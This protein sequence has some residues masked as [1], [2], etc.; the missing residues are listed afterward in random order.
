MCGIAG[1]LEFGA[2]ARVDP[3]V[4]RRMCDVMAHRGPD[5]DGFFIQGKIGLGMR[6]LSIVDLSTGHQP[7]GNEDG[8]LWIVF[9]GEIYNHRALRER[10]ITRG[11]QFRTQSDTESIV[12]L[13]E[14]YG[15]NCV[16]HLRGMFA[17]AIWDVKQ[18][19]LFVARDRLGIKPLYYRL[20]PKSFI[21]GSE[22]KVLLAY[23]GATPELNRGALPEFLSF[24]YLSGDESFY[25]GVRKLMPGHRLEID[26][27]G[28]PHVEQYW[29]LALT[30]EEKTHDEEFYVKSYRELLEGAVES[31]LMSDVP[32]GVFL[33]GGLD[34]SAV[35][36]L[37][38]RIRREPVE[39][40]SVGYSEQTYSELPYART[41]AQHLNSVHHEV[42]VSREDFFGALPNLIWHEDEPIVWPSSVSLFFVAQLARERVKVVLTGEGSDETLAG[43]SRYAFILKN[44]A[45]DRFYRGLVPSGVRS[46]VRDFIA[47]SS[48]IN[49]S[50]RRKL[51]HTFLGRDGESWASF[52]FDNFFSAFNQRDQSDLLADDFR[53]EILTGSAYRNVL[54]YWEK[55][56]GELL[57]RLLYTDIK[58]Y[59]VE[60][61]MKQDNMSMAAS[62]ESRVPF[63][64]HVLVEWATRVPA[65]VQIQG[66]SGKWI[67]KKAMEDLLPPSIIN[68]RKLG[69]PTPWSGWL[70]GSQ[71]DSIEQLLLES[72]T[73]NRGLLK[74]AAVER[75]FR[76]HRAQYR[77]HYD[78][79]WRLLNLELWHRVCL[80]G[81]SHE[82]AGPSSGLR[83]VPI[84]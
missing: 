56:S 58:T 49:A 23:P 19:S 18:Q 27:R 26:Q 9:N 42:F 69:F 3:G 57:Q 36:A 54:G 82:W 81:E 12:H 55:S 66:P 24:G 32:L 79:I 67:L 60:L 41:M 15:T 38:T 30:P 39:T 8:S 29:D 75:L 21:F 73:M 70:G 65:S 46:S 44:T 71:L 13:Y 61:L 11:H 77:D 33:S 72:R 14:E 48:W 76:E 64:D 35:A 63:L 50:A 84:A 62:I 28:N 31:H 7:I 5:D 17:F 4:L 37:M 40:F 53:D 2:E 80:E 68:R 1:I 52:Y 45:F 83:S 10:L 59:L 25:N 34:S 20:T 6:R 78:R 22:I 51:S 43:Y 74:R 47:T 16:E